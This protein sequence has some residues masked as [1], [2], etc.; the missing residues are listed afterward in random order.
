MTQDK[1][2][3]KYPYKPQ[4]LTLF[5]G[6][7]FFGCAAWFLAHEAQ[8]NDQGI[9]LVFI[10]HIIELTLDTNQ[11]TYLL[12]GLAVLSA[13]IALLCLYGLYLSLTS[14]AEL[15]LTDTSITIPT[16]GIFSCKKGRTIHFTDI[17]SLE[18]LTINKIPFLRIV[19]SKGKMDISSSLL[20]KKT[21]IDEIYNIIISTQLKA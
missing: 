6:I 14:K 17:H 12:W 20:P 2:R 5:L 16:T 11:A 8:L 19:D 3:K 13:L 4:K 15:V 10:R 1:F 9:T 18:I 7:P 21:I